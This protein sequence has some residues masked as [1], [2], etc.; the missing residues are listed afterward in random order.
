MAMIINY[1]NVQKVH[2][3][4]VVGHGESEMGILSVHESVE[5]SEFVFSGGPYEKNVVN[6]PFVAG[7]VLLKR[8]LL[9]VQ[10][11]LLFIEADVE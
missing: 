5:I 11:D 1:K 6:V 2:F 4:G 7:D 3:G 9:G 10:N 8:I